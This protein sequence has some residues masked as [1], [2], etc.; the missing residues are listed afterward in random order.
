M[1]GYVVGLLV[2]SPLLEEVTWREMPS[3]LEQACMYSSIIA[4]LSMPTEMLV[5][6][7]DSTIWSFEILLVVAFLGE[8]T[9]FVRLLAVDMSS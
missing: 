1:V 8:T 6:S 5:A 3:L 7:D 9:A 2:G 4:F